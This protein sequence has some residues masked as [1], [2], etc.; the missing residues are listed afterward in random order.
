MCCQTRLYALDITTGANKPNSPAIVAATVNFPGQPFLVCSFLVGHARGAVC[1]MSACLREPCPTLAAVLCA[2]DLSH[3][4]ALL[5]AWRP[6]CSTPLRSCSGRRLSS[7]TALC[8][9]RMAPTATTSSTTLVGVRSQE[10]SAHARPAMLL[11]FIL[12]RMLSLSPGV[13]LPACSDCWEL[14]SPCAAC[15]CLSWLWSKRKGGCRAFHL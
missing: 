1:C 8:S 7:P 11:P 10:L 15:C 2:H 3:V 12:F 14:C 13:I 5:Q 4:L 9:S 6:S